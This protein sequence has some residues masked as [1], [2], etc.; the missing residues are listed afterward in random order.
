VI[1]HR[2]PGC[3]T[4]RRGCVCRRWSELRAVPELPVGYV[5]LEHRLVAQLRR[6]QQQQQQQRQQQRRQVSLTY[7]TEDRSS[8]IVHAAGWHTLGADGFETMWSLHP[9]RLGCNTFQG[10]T[11]QTPR[12]FRAYGRSYAF[13]GQVAEALPLA[14]APLA[15][16][17]RYRIEALLLAIDGQQ[18][19][20][21]HRDGVTCTAAA[22]ATSSI[23]KPEGVP[24]Q[25]EG[26]SVAATQQQQPQQP[27]HPPPA[28]NGV[29]VN[30]YGPSHSIGL[31]RDDTRELLPHAPIW[32]LSWG[33]RRLFCLRPRDDTDSTT[34]S[35]SANRRRSGDH[36]HGSGGGGGGGGGCKTVEIVLGHGDLLIM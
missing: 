30:W 22:S 13:S 5:G 36:K 31:H 7:L 33:H 20:Q 29:L 6:Q 32:S 23:A 11:V 17:A 26:D 4:L 14:D 12:Y 27:H 9:P 24:S 8:W 28:P 1:V 15:A 10:R 18:P 16:A 21:A 34:S 19:T 35:D 3:A 2:H 25:A